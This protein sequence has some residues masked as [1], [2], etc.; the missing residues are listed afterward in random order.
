MKLCN[1]GDFQFS[2]RIARAAHILDGLLPIRS[3]TGVIVSPRDRAEWAAE[4]VVHQS[5]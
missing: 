5:T 1:P 2:P 3:T 4:I